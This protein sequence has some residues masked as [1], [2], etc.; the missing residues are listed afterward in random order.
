MRDLWFPF[1]LFGI[2]VNSTDFLHWFHHF[3]HDLCSS[4]RPVWISFAVITSPYREYPS[5]FKI[6]ASALFTNCASKLPLLI[7]ILYLGDYGHQL[8]DKSLTYHSDERSSCL[9]GWN[10]HDHSSRWLVL[11]GPLTAFFLFR[12]NLRLKGLLSLKLLL[13]FLWWWIY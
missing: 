12:L 13:G 8:Y 1:L 6:T 11:I 5:N 4:F 10:I 9:L 7:F 2:N 3:C